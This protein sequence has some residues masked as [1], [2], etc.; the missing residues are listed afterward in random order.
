MTVPAVVVLVYLISVETQT[1][2]NNIELNV[3]VL[4]RTF[5]ITV[6]YIESPRLSP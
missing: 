5:L 1:N 6:S 2:N 3:H 4:E